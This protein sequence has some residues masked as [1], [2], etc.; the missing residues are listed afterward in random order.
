MKKQIQKRR[1]MA[2]SATAELSLLLPFLLLAV[3]GITDF[4][5]VCFQTIAIA[6]AAHAGA[7]Y[8]S[9]SPAH[10]GDEMG[11]RTAVLNELSDMDF[12]ETL[13]VQVDQYCECPDG[14]V[15]DCVSGTCGLAATRTFVSVRIEKPFDALFSYPG[16]P[17]NLT[18]AR[19]A[20]VRAM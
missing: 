9:H 18:L 11:I 14:T 12:D 1:G 4:S 17:D 5:R 16:I 7:K 15:I 13:L 20:H 6:N 19:E 3:L 10:I 8:G 2:G